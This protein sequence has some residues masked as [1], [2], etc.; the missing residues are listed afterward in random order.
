MQ[1]V[2]LL[3]DRQA[4]L[5]SMIEDKNQVSEQSNGKYHEPIFEEMKELEEKKSNEA[6]L[7]VQ[8]RYTLWKY[9]NERD[10]ARRLQRFG[11]TRRMKKEADSQDLLSFD[12]C[13][14]FVVDQVEEMSLESPRKMLDEQEVM[15]ETSWN[16]RRG[17][18]ERRV[19]AGTRRGNG[20]AGNVSNRVEGVYVDPNG[21]GHHEREASNKS[22]RESEAP[23][24]KR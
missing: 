8:K 9:Q 17:R 14:S 16:A 5:K 18:G 6:L 19:E 7:L 11:N 20:D 23:G 12:S 1:T 10:V 3:G 24:E 13:R 4:I 15:R 21:E 22:R 2:T